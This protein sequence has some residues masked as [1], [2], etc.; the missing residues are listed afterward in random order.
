MLAGAAVLICIFG[1]YV[2]FQDDLAKGQIN[3]QERGYW[4]SRGHGDNIINTGYV[5]RSIVPNNLISSTDNERKRYDNWCSW[6]DGPF[7]SAYPSI[8]GL[9][10]QC[11]NPRLVNLVLY[12]YNIAEKLISRTVASN[13]IPNCNRLAAL[14]HD[15]NWEDLDINRRGIPLVGS[16][17]HRFHSRVLGIVP[18][19]RYVGWLHGNIYPSSVSLDESRLSDVGLSLG[20]AKTQYDTRRSEGGKTQSDPSDPINAVLG[21]NAPI[22]IRLLSGAVFFL[23]GMLLIRSGVIADHTRRVLVG[24]VI[25][26]LSGFLWIPCL[27]YF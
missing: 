13:S 9:V 1:I 5:M 17:Y 27:P 4:M 20:F 24:W 25:V 18:F 15:K 3:S 16:S 22:P 19:E 7:N 23:G 12:E 2:P 8:N 11:H 14:R 26:F 21:F 10:V 6:R